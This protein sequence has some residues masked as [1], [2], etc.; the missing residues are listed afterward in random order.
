MPAA[1]DINSSDKGA[2][3]IRFCD[4]FNIPLISLVDVPGFLPGVSQEHGGIIRHGAKILYA[5]A[6][7]TVPKISLII[8]KSYGGAF[9]AMSAK[10][11]GYDRTLAYPSSEIAVMGAEG[12]ANVIFRRDINAAD[13]PAARRQEQINEFKEEVMNPFHSCRLRIC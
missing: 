6:E 10:Q 3:F 4:A 9:I 13:D 1:L 8:R 7:A 2:R 12:A 11:L 5:M